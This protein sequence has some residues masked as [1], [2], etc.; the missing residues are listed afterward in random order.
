MGT[1]ELAQ[2]LRHQIGFFQSLNLLA[3]LTAAE[4]VALPLELD[5]VRAKAAM[6][7]ARS[8]LESVGLLA[9][10]DRF[11]AGLSGGEQ[12]RVTIA[13]AVVGGRSRVVLRHRSGR[14]VRQPVP[15]AG[16]PDG[17]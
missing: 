15:R 9:V 10:A 12:Q 3:S 14:R 8:L 13:R 17:A 16:G 11:P 4:N 6:S 7:K 2:V 5:G 1:A